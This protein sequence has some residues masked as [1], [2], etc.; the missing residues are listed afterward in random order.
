[1]SGHVYDTATG[2]LTT[3]FEPSTPRPGQRG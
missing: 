3:V 2:V 1:V